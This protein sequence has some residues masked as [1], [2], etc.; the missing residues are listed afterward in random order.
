V[1]IADTFAECGPYDELLDKYGM[2][3]DAIVDAVRR[4]LQRKTTNRRLREYS[5]EI[6]NA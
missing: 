1:G 2:R 5:E 3:A 4:V 6:R